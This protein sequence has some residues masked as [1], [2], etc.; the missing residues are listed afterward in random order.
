MKHYLMHQSFDPTVLGATLEGLGEGAEHVLHGISNT[1]TNAFHATFAGA[2]KLVSGPLQLLVNLVVILII[3]ITLIF[4]M[5]LITLRILRNAKIR[6][7]FKN[8]KQPPL[9]V[10]QQKFHSIDSLSNV[11][12]PTVTIHPNSIKNIFQTYYN[13]IINRIC[14]TDA[15]QANDQ[16]EEHKIT[17]EQ[18]TDLAGFMVLHRDTTDHQPTEE[19]PFEQYTVCSASSNSNY[20]CILECLVEGVP[21]VSL[22]DSGSTKSIISSKVAKLLKFT[23]TPTTDKLSSLS[24]HSLTVLGTTLV[25]LRIGHQQYRNH[26]VIVVESLD[27]DLILGF[28]FLAR[29]GSVEFRLGHEGNGRLLVGDEAIPVGHTHLTRRKLFW[30]AYFIQNSYIPGQT[31]QILN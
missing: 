19:T 18:G 20:Q 13:Q 27:I 23:I 17:E 7:Q 26:S 3:F 11:Y 28:D 24:G 29:M 6:N 9:P 15:T 10:K 31:E 8:R 21:L 22:L 4:I 30:P 5:Y 2:N 14:C 25:N 12:N 1:W 16:P